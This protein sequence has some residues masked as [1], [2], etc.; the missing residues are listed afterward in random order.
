MVLGHVGR[1][2]E[3]KNHKFLLEIFEKISEKTDRAVL[4]LVGRGELENARATKNASIPYS[5]KC[6]VFRINP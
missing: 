1:F 5:T 3:A 2:T 4:L 6:A